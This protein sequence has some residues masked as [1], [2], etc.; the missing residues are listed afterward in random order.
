ME[1]AQSI[2]RKLKYA[3]TLDMPVT[4]NIGTV[5][6]GVSSQEFGNTYQHTT[7]LSIEKAAALT[8]ADNASI[9]DGHLIYT[10]PAGNIIVNNAYMVMLVTNAEHDGETLEAG[11]GTTTASGAVSVLSGTAGFENVLTGQAGTVGIVTS[12]MDISNSTS[13]IGGLL[14]PAASAHTVYFNVA[15]AWAN[16]AGTALNT[17]I[18]GAVI[19]NWTFFV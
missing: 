11:L 2:V 18:Q 13:G 17:D 19:L 8:L 6:S 12:G 10:L 5:G 4:T 15:G 16:T 1:S 14:I 9:G 7:V 3:G